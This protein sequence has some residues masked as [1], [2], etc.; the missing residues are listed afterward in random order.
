MH[1]KFKLMPE[2]L[3]LTTNL[4][5]WYLCV[6]SVSRK[7]LLL[8]GMIAMLLIAKYEEIWAPEVNDFVHMSNNTY[9]R[10]EVLTMEK[11]MLNTLKF[12]LTVPTPYVFI[13]QLL[14]ASACDKQE[15][16]MMPQVKMVAWFLVELC[17]AEYPMIKYSPSLLA[18]T[19]VYI[20]H[21][22]LAR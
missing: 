7:N 13:V 15:K 22:T 11:N 18:A 21:I 9:L 16:T 2:T 17:L 8:V 6:Q 4:I 3:F 12:N 14:K 20:A 5:D 19:A 10:E 1:L